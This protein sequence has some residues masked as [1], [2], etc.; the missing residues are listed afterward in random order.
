[1]HT[2]HI[3]TK[4]MSYMYN[5]YISPIQSYVVTSPQLVYRYR[6]RPFQALIIILR[7]G[8]GEGSSKGHV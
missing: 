2:L 4:G 1:M 8:G 6:A 5:E 3:G 7:A